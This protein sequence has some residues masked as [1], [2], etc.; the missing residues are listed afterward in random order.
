MRIVRPA[1]GRAAWLLSALAASCLAGAP[2]AAQREQVFGQGQYY[3]EGVRAFCGDI[4]TVVTNQGPE[5]IHSPNPYTIVVNGPV[6]DTLPPGVRLFVYFQTCGVISY[7]MMPNGIAIADAT[8]ARRGIRERWLA[9]SDI[10]AICQ[11][12]LPAEIGWAQ[13]PDAARCEAIYQVM[14]DA[15]R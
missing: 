1:R 14:I 13:A 6:F 10:E 2:A 12:G 5:L 3:I 9:A 4:E 7:S 11:T 8:A 15:M